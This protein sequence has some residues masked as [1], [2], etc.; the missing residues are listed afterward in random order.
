MDFQINVKRF[1]DMNASNLVMQQY[2]QKFNTNEILDLLLQ[3][4]RYS[5]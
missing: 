4:Q 1:L 5:F 3:I 2:E